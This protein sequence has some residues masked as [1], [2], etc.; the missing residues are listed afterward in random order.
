MGIAIKKSSDLYKRVNSIFVSMEK[1]QIFFESSQGIEILDNDT[2]VMYILRDMDDHD[3][4]TSIPPQFEFE[5]F[6]K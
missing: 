4:I 1:K 2:G 6:E 5:I 3:P